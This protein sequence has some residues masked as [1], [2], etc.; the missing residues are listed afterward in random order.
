MKLSAKLIGG[1][2]FVALITLAV[3]LAGWKSTS[4]ITAQ[5]HKVTDQTLITEKF[6]R[7]N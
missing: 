5:L 2:C 4:D 3:G 6:S 7:I 1:F